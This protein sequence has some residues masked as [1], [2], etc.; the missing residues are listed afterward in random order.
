M[1]ALSEPLARVQLGRGGSLVGCQGLGCMGMSEFY[2]QTDEREALAT[3]DRALE[4]GVSLLDTADMYGVGANERFLGGFVRAHRDKVFIGTKFGYARTPERPDDWSLDNRPEHI[5]RAVEGSLQRLGIETIDLYYMHR[6]DPAIPLEDSIGAMAALVAA[7]K[8]RA[9][10]LSEVSAQELRAAHAI[11]PIAALQSEWS[12][13]SRGIEREVVPTAAELGVAVVP[14]A[15]LGRGLLTQSGFTAQL[16]VGDA[17]LNFPRF[18]A[19]NAE[20]NAPLVA[21]IEE[22]ALARGVTAAQIAL[23]WLHAQGRRLGVTLVPIPGTRRRQR[24]DENVAAASIALSDAEM[25]ELDAIASQV[26][27]AGI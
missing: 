27:G 6:R 3:L 24:L 21:H 5:R 11:H 26:R 1:K 15:P 4:L 9:L 18:G 7:G 14:Y 16:G 20:A 25:S 12:L 8:V 2:G 13:F 22:L 19:E 17:R 23:A 10:G